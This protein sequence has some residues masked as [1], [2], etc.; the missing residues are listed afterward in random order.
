MDWR[1]TLGLFLHFVLLNFMSIGG[2]ST[3]L[4]DM[5]R[6]VVEANHWMTGKQFADA[7]ALAHAAP[8]PNVMYVTLIGWQVAGWLGA[9]ATTVPLVIPALTLTML[10]IRL[11]ARNPDAPLSRAIRRGLAPISVGLTLASGSIL[12]RAGAG[13]W[14]DGVLIA[15]AFL[16]ALRLKCNPLWLMGAGAIAGIAGIV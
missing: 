13:D 16:A 5:Y 9:L 6:Y 11:N 10:V 4:P 3:V 14:P 2:T 7:Y 15:I 8:G 12:V 1:E